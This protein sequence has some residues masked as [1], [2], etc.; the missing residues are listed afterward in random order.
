MRW[1]PFQAGLR[2]AILVGVMAPCLASCQ[3]V[4][5]KAQRKLPPDLRERLSARIRT[6]NAA[7]EAGLAAL[8]HPPSADRAEAAGWDLGKAT[9][10]IGDVLERTSE[11]TPEALEVHRTMGIASRSLDDAV[12]RLQTPDDPQTDA[13]VEDARGSL[14]KAIDLAAEFL[15][16]EEPEP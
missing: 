4:Y 6:A 5:D 1:R 14:Q 13:A 10:S 15:S 16:D 8:A 9:A 2:A 12:L 7:A 11:P 3:S